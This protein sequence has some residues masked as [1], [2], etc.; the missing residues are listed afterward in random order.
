MHL[1]ILK[2][3]VEKGCPF[4]PYI[5]R[6]HASWNW[7]QEM[8]DWI[9]KYIQDHQDEMGSEWEQPFPFIGLGFNFYTMAAM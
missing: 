9:A 6:N 1:H 2:W 4:N 8:V 3:A 5:C 7:D